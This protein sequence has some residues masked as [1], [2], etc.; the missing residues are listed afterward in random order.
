MKE[1]VED[2]IQLMTEA[3]LEKKLQVLLI[4]I[5]T[6]DLLISTLYTLSAFLLSH[7]KLMAS[8]AVH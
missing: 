1:I 5:Q 2:A 7:G 8:W 3:H 4:M 6:S